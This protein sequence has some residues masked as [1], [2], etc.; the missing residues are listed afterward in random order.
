V[1]H[2][3]LDPPEALADPR[4][5]RLDNVVRLRVSTPTT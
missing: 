4:H 5:Q 1:A 2:P 3:I